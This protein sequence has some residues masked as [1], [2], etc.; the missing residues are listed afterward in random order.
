MKFSWTWP[1]AVEDFRPPNRL[2]CGK[3]KGGMFV[4]VIHAADDDRLIRVAL[5]EG[6]DYFMTDS[7]PEERAPALAG[8]DLTDPNPARAVGIL[9]TLSVPVKLHFHPAILVAKDLL[10][11]RTDHGRRLGSSDRRFGG[12]AD[13]PVRQR[14]RNASEAILVVVTD[15]ATASVIAAQASDV[16][17]SRQ[18]VRAVRVEVTFQVELVPGAEV[19]AVAAA[20]D[21][22]NGHG[23]L[24]HPDLDG[25]LA[26]LEDLLGSAGRGLP[27]GSTPS[28]RW[29]EPPG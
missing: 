26:V 13:G 24:L 22:Q 9:L 28:N 17:D 7:R 29:A 23:F 3:T 2:D 10:A 18:Q 20:L 8:P 1:R 5:F 4:G 11:G 27:P 16:L 14:C 6:D 19:P 12:T 25:P 15:V 21:C